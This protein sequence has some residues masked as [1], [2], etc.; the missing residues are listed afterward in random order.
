MLIVARA[1]RITLES[2]NNNNMSSCANCGK[3]EEESIGLKACMACKLVKYC[4][5]ACQKAHRSQHKKEC[6]KR[7]AELHDEAL[8][9][10]PPKDEDCP[11]CFLTLPSLETG[12]RYNACCGKAICSGCIYAGAMTGD[13]LLCPFCRTPAPKTGEETHERI[14]NR[15]KLDDAV[16]IYNLGC[17]YSSGECGFQQDNDKALELWHRAGELGCAAAYHNIGVSYEN[18]E[19]V[20]RDEKNAKHH[21]EVAAIGGVVDARHNLGSVEIRAGNMNRALKHYMIAVEG[22]DADSLKTVKQLFTKGLATRDD[23]AKALRAYQAYID[24]IRSD[25]RDEAAAFS[26]EYKYCEL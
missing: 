12:R 6:R 1:R 5:A 9:K 11:I 24:D 10:Q 25:Q 2:T 3:G 15:V 8:F 16:A 20:E 4:N 26:E 17:D 7:A 18:G 13:D 22:G 14:E 19:G 21:W 23:Y